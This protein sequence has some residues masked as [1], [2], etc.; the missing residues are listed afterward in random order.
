MHCQYILQ[1]SLLTLLSLPGTLAQTWSVWY[2]DRDTITDICASKGSSVVFDCIYSYPATKKVGRKIWFT[3]R[4]DTKL[5]GSQQGD[6]V[7]NTRGLTNKSRYSGRTEFYDQDNKCTLKLNNVT[8]DDSGRFFFRFEANKPHQTPQGFTGSFG[9]ALTI[10]VL[11]LKINENGPVKERD[12]VT[13]AC[14]STCNPPQMEFLWFKDGRPLPG[15][16]GVHGGQYL[17]GPLSP[18]DTGSYSCGLGQSTSTPILLDMRYAPRNVSVKV[19]LSHEVVK[20]SHLTLTCSNNANPAAET[21][22]WFQRTGTLTSLRLGMGKEHT[23]LEIDSD[24]SGLY[25]CMAQ[26]AVGSQNSTELEL[27]VKESA[28]LMVVLAAFGALF[29]V[30]AVIVVLFIYIKRRKLNTAEKKLPT[31]PVPQLQKATLSRP[32]DIYEN[33]KWSAKPITD[34]DDMNYAELNIR[35]APSPRMQRNNKA[36]DDDAV[37]YRQLQTH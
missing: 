30:T 17:L 27:K 21:Y 32:E 35:P 19:S 10:P 3:P 14:T 36:E 23:F 5:D 6:G 24:D 16:S 8:E 4:G 13:L 31:K 11:S 15:V 33:M 12:Y 29:L 28:H 37:I 20:G 7:F 9:V 2:R 26:N 1:L 25:F 34:P 22:T 18:N